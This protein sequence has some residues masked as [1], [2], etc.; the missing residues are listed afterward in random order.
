MI[1]STGPQLITDQT[2]EAY[3]SSLLT[4]RDYSGTSTVVREYEKM[5]ETY[6]QVNHVIAVSSGTAAIHAGLVAMGIGKGCR[7]AVPAICAVMTVVP[8]VQLGAIP[9]VIDSDGDSFCMDPKQLEREMEKGLKVVIACGMWGNPGTSKAMLSLSERF[10]VPILED[11]AQSLGA[12]T[13]CGREG[14]KGRIGCFSTH[15][16]KLLSTGEGGFITTNDADIAERLRAF[17]RLGFDGKAYGNQFGVNYK[18]SGFQAI[19]GMNAIRNLAS[20]LSR[21]QELC[22]AWEEHL[23]GVK[24]LAPIQVAD[25]GTS[26]P[27]ACIMLFDDDTDG[28]RFAEELAAREFLTDP[29]RYELK[30]ITCYPVFSDYHPGNGRLPNAISFL[31][32]LLVLPVHDNISLQDITNGA[33]II[34]KIRSI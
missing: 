31:H 10:N 27:Y 15:E 34:K 6:F 29:Y 3:R 19:A 32:R 8:V 14:L 25:S 24:H 28:V 17:I 16:Y 22:V 1:K 33:R 11:A 23:S 13:P 9:V 5:L 12:S 26:A 2:A 7:V 21:R 30:P 20:Y 4:Y 18:L